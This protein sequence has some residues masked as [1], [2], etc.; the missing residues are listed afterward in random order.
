MPPEGNLR[1][2]LHPDLGPCDILR[3][4]GTDWVIKAV[5]TGKVY[6]VPPAQRVRFSTGQPAASTP[7]QQD[8]PAASP[9]AAPHAPPGTP[10]DVRTLRRVIESLRNGLP[11]LERH[12]RSLAVGFNHTLTALNAFFDKVDKSGGDVIVVRG[13]YGQGKSFTLRVLQEM[14]LE[15]G[16]MVA[17]TE[18]DASEIQ[19]HKPYLVY[20]DLMRHLRLPGHA[21]PGVA[22]LAE[23]IAEIVRSRYHAAGNR[24]YVGRAQEWL[25]K[26]LECK[27]L[28]WLL[29]DPHL[30]QK[31]EL[32]GL[33]ICDR[34]LCVTLARRSHITPCIPRTWPGFNAGTQGDFAGFLLSGLGRLARLLG[35]RGLIIVMDE[36]ERWQD[37]NWPQQTRAGNLLGGLIWAATAQN[38]TRSEEDRP[39]TLKHSLRCG[40]YPFTTPSRCHLGLAIAMTPC[41]ADGPESLWGGYGPLTVHD[42]KSF[43]RQQVA[44]YCT[45]LAPTYAAAYQLPAPSDGVLDPIRKQAILTWQQQ[46]IATARSVVQAAVKA[47]DD[48]KDNVAQG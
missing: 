46:G 34:S 37:L 6:R 17:H 3:I 24:W 21:S 32:L 35:H 41:G 5:N 36:M 18:I 9:P 13:A 11:P 20:G 44:D 48:W 15:A 1:R 22:S 26:E 29:S 43:S 28:A 30:D 7:A 39:A 16:F 45:I 14:A 4:E 12:G 38:G 33:L 40:G 42:L 8:V 47:F 23:K 10:P 31:E 25:L 27:S 19:L 2:V